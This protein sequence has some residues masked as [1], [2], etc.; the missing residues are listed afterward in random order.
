MY[1]NY[2]NR[3]IL[4]IISFIK[5]F[6]KNLSKKI[7]YLSEFNFSI[8]CSINA[9]N[10]PNFPEDTSYI[11]CIV[12][13]NVRE[14]VLTKTRILCYTRKNIKWSKCVSTNSS[15]YSMFD[16]KMWK[17]VF[18]SGNIF[19][20]IIVFNSNSRACINGSTDLYSYFYC[21]TAQDL[22]MPQKLA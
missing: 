13:D 20:N 15:F 6:M 1:I 11:G 3:I 4:I 16:E 22:M 9:S 8:L 14:E 2:Y 10:R 21:P 5:S 17:F 18:V 19:K 12:R 7:N